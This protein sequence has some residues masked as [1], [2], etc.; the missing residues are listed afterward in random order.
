MNP[1]QQ[2]FDREEARRLRAEGLTD[3]QIAAR[4]GVSRSMIGKALGQFTKRKGLKQIVYDAHIAN[5]TLTRSELVSLTGVPYTSLAR[6]VC[7][8][9][10]PVPTEKP[11]RFDRDEARRLREKNMTYQAIA[12]Q[13]GVSIISVFKAIRDGGVARPGTSPRR[14]RKR[15]SDL[16]GLTAD[17]AGQ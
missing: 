15:P 11:L 7:D 6:V 9:K 5:P 3:T 4:L 8:L 2:L 14:K 1:H 17:N 10:L 12:D 16:S 13:L